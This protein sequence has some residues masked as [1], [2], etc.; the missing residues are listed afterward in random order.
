MDKFKFH[1][2][3]FYFSSMCSNGAPLCKFVEFF[4]STG[5]FNFL[6]L[7]SSTRQFQHMW[8]KLNPPLCT[9]KNILFSFC[10]MCVPVTYKKQSP[11]HFPIVCYTI[12]TRVNG[13][14]FFKTINGWTKCPFSPD[15]GGPPRTEACLDLRT[16]KE[17]CIVM[18]FMQKFS[19]LSILIESLHNFFPTSL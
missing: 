7:Y 10:I 2:W 5:M 17:N 18:G 14:S 8:N 16:A 3:I 11:T 1:V 19:L 12:Y 13:N 15:F 6:L 4:T 9:Q